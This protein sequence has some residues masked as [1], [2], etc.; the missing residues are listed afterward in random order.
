MGADGTG[1]I[2][3]PLEEFWAFAQKY[4]PRLEGESVY[5]VPRVENDDLV[6][7][8]AFSTE[9]HPNTWATKPPAVVQWDDQKKKGG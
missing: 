5:G 8:Y 4:G 1:T 9:A 2:Y 7:D 3:I 6:I